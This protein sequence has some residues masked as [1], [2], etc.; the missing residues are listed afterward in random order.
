[1]V[2][3][4]NDTLLALP[5]LP[6]YFSVFAWCA[7]FGAF[8]LIVVYLLMSLGAIS[9]LK[10]DPKKVELW[11]SVILGLLV[12]GA[13]IF[14]SFYKVP[15]PTLIAPWAAVIWGVLG[16]LYMFAVKGREPASD[17]LADL[18]S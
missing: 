15:S 4:A 18:R 13:A 9:G 7:T 1:V 2:A 17:A 8:A 11:C 10:D 16:L 12:T 14:G 5:G 3:E 6:H